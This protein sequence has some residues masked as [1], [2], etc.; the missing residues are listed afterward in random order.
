MCDCASNVS[1]ESTED[2]VKQKPNKDK[3]LIQNDV[4]YTGMM[5]HEEKKVGYWRVI[6]SVVRD[7]EVLKQYIS[8]NHPNAELGNDVDFFKFSE[9]NGKLLLLLETTQLQLGWTVDPDREPME[10]FQS[11][12]DHFPLN[13]LYSSCSMSVYAKPGIAQDP[14]HCPIKLTGIDP[15]KIVYINKSPPALPPSMSP[16]TSSS[17][18][19]VHESTSLSSTRGASPSATVDVN[20]VKKVIDDVLV[21]HYADLNSLKTSLSDLASQL[22]AAHLISDEVRETRSM[23]KF[24]TEFKASLSF[25][26]KLPQ[27]QEHCQKFLS[28][29]IAVRGSYADAAIALGEDWIEAIRNELGLDFNINIDA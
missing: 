11:T 2:E 28:S 15:S 6:Y 3:A 10:L 1:N 21:S 17:S 29:F 22:Y 27:V 26:R 12:I 13:P 20:K 24:I 4:L 19:V 9:P 7:L 25:K 23:E 8:T 5:Y 14:L 18:N 16:T